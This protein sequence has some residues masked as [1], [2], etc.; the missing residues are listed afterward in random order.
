MTLLP[1]GLRWLLELQPLHLLL[2]RMKEEGIKKDTPSSIRDSE[3]MLHT[4][5]L[6]LSHGPEVSHRASF[7]LGSLVPM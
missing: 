7:Y 1:L 3:Q 5:L 2:S 4:P 6:L